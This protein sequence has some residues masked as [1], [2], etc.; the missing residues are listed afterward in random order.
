MDVKS[1]LTLEIVL[2]ICG[3]G[4]CL[5]DNFPQ[6]CLLIVDYYGNI[7]RMETKNHSYVNISTKNPVTTYDTDYDP[8][9]DVIFR[10]EFTNT[11]FPKISATSMHGTNQT[12]IHSFN[13]TALPYGMAVDAISRLLF[14]ADAGNRVI[15]VI[16]L[17]DYSHK[18]V[19][20]SN[21]S[22]PRYIV[23]DPINGTI[24]W[25]DRASP[26]KIEKSSYS[27]T[28]RNIIVDT[29]LSLPSGLAL[30]INEGVIYW[31]DAGTIQRVNLDGYNRR[32]IYNTLPMDVTPYSSA[33]YQSYLYFTNWGPSRSVM[34]I[35]KDG[36]GLSSVGPSAFDYIMDICVYSNGTAALENNGCSN[37]ISNC[38]HFCFPLPGGSKMCACPDGMI[39]QSDGRTC[40]NDITSLTWTSTMT[41]QSD[42]YL[43]SPGLSDYFPN[44]FILILDYIGAIYQMDINNHTYQEIPIQNALATYDIDYD[45]IDGI[46]FRNEF[47][48]TGLRQISSVSIY[49]INRKIIHSFNSNALP[50]GIAVD[51][52]SRLLFYADAGN[53]IIG[54]I[55]LRDYLH[56]TVIS[57]NLSFPRYIATDPKSG[58]IFWIDRGNPSTIEKSTYTGKN[59]QVLINTGLSLPSGLALDI[60]DGVMYWCDS[61]TI[62]RANVDGSNRQIIYRTQGTEVTPYSSAFY[63][64]YLYFT[65]WG[66]S[67]SLMR[68]GKDGSG[69]TSVS[70][71]AFGYILDIYV[72]SKAS[73]KNGC[74]NAS[75]GCSHFCFPLS[76]GYVCDCPD[77]M[78]LQPDGQSCRIDVTSLSSTTIPTSPPSN[79][80]T[81]ELTSLRAAVGALAGLLVISVF[82]NVCFIITYRRMK[83]E[84]KKDLHSVNSVTKEDRIVNVSGISVTQIRKIPDE[85][86]PVFYPSV[87]NI[88]PI[89]QN[90]VYLTPYGNEA[91]DGYT[92]C[93]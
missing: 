83:M 52:I 81:E 45:H 91:G 68:V 28:N 10:N 67:R 47:T 75:G 24:I 73:G 19:I 5:A 17:K 30:D 90:D 35:G 25:I 88:Q 3:Y 16:S 57:S 26:A 76:R 21:L 89:T 33:L 53:H 87:G 78:T 92:E 66:P 13:I 7:Y 2:L 31:C 58:T 69:L 74:S 79:G 4:Q 37:G 56:K 22:F 80:V 15:G 32:T 70:A 51:A 14:Y 39:L 86:Y 82:L 77:D 43:S 42:R 34:R 63:Q 54:V 40:G 71:P 23:T 65:Y 62:Q 38:S 85:S 61:G 11:S 1:I 41:T 9:D 60:N 8:I 48:Y 49:G 59:R 44:N 84:T 93:M 72:H 55:S 18:T 12:R 20:S 46:I 64:S 27:G 6:E 50:Y 29:A 36:N